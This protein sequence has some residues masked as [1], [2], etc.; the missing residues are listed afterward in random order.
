V[1]SDDAAHV[2]Q[3]NTGAFKVGG[4]MEPLEDAEQFMR[5]ARIETDAIVLN[6]NDIF[7]LAGTAGYLDAGNF[8]G[9]GVFKRI[10]QQIEHDLAN[11]GRVRL[12]AGQLGDGPFDLA[13]FRVMPKIPD[14]GRHEILQGNLGFIKFGAGGTGKSE[15]IID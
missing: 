2:S 8:T 14:N 11:Q 3:A 13:V 15:Q 6:E 10:L 1:A 4:A 12:D 5:I 9:A 7:A